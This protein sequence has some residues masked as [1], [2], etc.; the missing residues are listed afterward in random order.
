MEK[1]KETN[2]TTTTTTI[3]TN[4]QERIISLEKQVTELKEIVQK[5]VDDKKWELP[6]IH[7]RINIL[8]A[9]I[10]RKVDK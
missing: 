2:A 3:I 4:L 7:E 8:T 10:R 9:L 6:S 1:R 5:L